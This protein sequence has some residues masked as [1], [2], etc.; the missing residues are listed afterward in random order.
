MISSNNLTTSQLL[1]NLIEFQLRSPEKSIRILGNC[2]R[3]CEIRSPIIL[4]RSFS[5]IILPV[6]PELNGFDEFYPLLSNLSSNGQ[7][8]HKELVFRT[9]YRDQ[10]RTIDIPLTYDNKMGY[11]IQSLFN[12]YAQ[13]WNIDQ[14]ILIVN[15]NRLLVLLHQLTLEDF[16]LKYEQKLYRLSI[17]EWFMAL[18]FYLQMDAQCFFM[19]TCSFRQSIP[20]CIDEGLF[21]L[22]LPSGQYG[23]KQCRDQSCG[24]CYERLV[25]T[26]RVNPAMSFSNRQIHHFVSGYQVYLNCNVIRTC[27][28][29][30][31]IYALTC[32]CHQ[33][34][35]IS[36][37][38][39]PIRECIMQHRINNGRI[40]SDF[41]LGQTV[42]DRLRYEHENLTIAESDTKLYQHSIECLMTIK[43]FLACHP[44]YW[45]F[46][47]MTSEQAAIDDTNISSIERSILVAYEMS[48]SE[49]NT[50]ERSNNPY[51]R[52]TT[53][54][55]WCMNNLP[56]PPPN[57]QYSLRQKL[58]QLN[59]FRDRLDFLTSRFLNLYNRTIVM[60]LPESASDEMGHLIQALLVTYAQPKLN[61]TVHDTNDP[62]LSSTNINDAWCQH[63]IHPRLCLS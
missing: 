30:N 32:P 22:A 41:F 61:R 27:I 46:V 43:I 63:L 19:Q 48:H 14:D 28:T 44:R 29:S 11:E 1:V 58:E 25:M 21:S 42:A 54:V 55:A 12:F 62:I 56:S 35:Y 4:N 20:R 39:V 10:G 31:V 34:D 3:E 8:T 13:K 38:D 17:E 47:P 16:I 18:E 51:Q 37:C 53:N 50:Y 24:Y 23:M 52:T 15:L 2:T 59:F 40:M 6:F 60:A 26:H 45:C 33:Y 5:R 49:Y 9:K 7:L 57:Y 36:R